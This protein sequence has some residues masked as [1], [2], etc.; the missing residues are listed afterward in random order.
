LLAVRGRRGVTISNQ[1]LTIPPDHPLAVELFD[2]IGLQGVLIN[3]LNSEAALVNAG[4][5]RTFLERNEAAMTMV[6]TKI[7]A[8]LQE[9]RDE[10]GGD[11]TCTVG[12]TYD[13]RFLPLVKGRPCLTIH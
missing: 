5:D 3:Q 11:E 7:E 8:L 9:Y 12:L 1:C 4:G 2:L 13:S 6:N 10:R